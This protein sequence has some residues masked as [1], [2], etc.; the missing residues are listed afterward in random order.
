MADR[1]ISELTNLTGANLADDDEFPL[2]D[3]S[4]DETKAITFGEFKTALD[5]ATGFVRITG[6]TMTGALDVQSTITADGLDLGDNERIRLGASQDLQILHNGLHSYIADSGT[7]NLYIQTTAGLIVQNS[8]GTETL[9][10]FTENG[11]VDLYYDNSVKVATSST[12]IDVTGG[13]T[14]DAYSYLNGLRISG[15]DTGNTVYQQSGDLSISSASGDISLKPSGTNILHA[16][17]TGVG[18]GTSSPSTRLTVGAGV[19]S[20]EIRVDAG[21]GWADLTLNSNATNGG[22]IYFNDGSNAGEIF[23]YH[24]SDYMAF[25]TAGSEAMRIDSSGNVG[26]GVTPSYTLDIASSGTLLNMNSTNSNG[27]GTVYR[28]SGTAIGY[29]GSSKYIHSGTIGDFAIGTASTNNL[30]FGVNSSEKMRIDSSGNV[31]IG[32]SSPSYK[33]DVDV[34]APSSSDQVLGR[35]SSQAGLRSIGYVWDDSQS[36]LGIATLTNHAMTFHI[37][38]NSNEKMR[39]DTS[40]NLLVGTTSSFGSSGITLGSNVVYAAASSQNVANFQ[41]YTTDGEI[42]RFG[43]DGTTVGSIGTSSN[44]EITLAGLDAGVGLIDHALV[45]TQGDGLLYR[46]DNEVDLGRSDTRFKDLYLSGSI[47]IENGTGNVGVGKQALNSNTADSN[48]AVGYQAG[49]TNVSGRS[50]TF[51]G[52]DAGEISTSSFNTYIGKDAGKLI[53]SGQKNT[54]LGSYNGNQ[55]G[56]DIRTSSSNIVLSDGDG[57]PRLRID[58]NGSIY[59]AQNPGANPSASQSGTVYLGGVTNFPYFINYVGDANTRYHFEFGNT[60]GSVGNIATNGTAT[61]YNTSSDYRLKENVVAMTGATTRLK[62]LNPSQFNFI[63]DADTTVDGFL[64][65]EVQAIVPE[66]IHGVKDEVDADGNPVYQGIDQSKLV[67][68]LVATIKELEARITAL[69]NA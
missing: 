34:G 8:A 21:A 30:T 60:N 59:F 36:T 26:I 41:R 49:Y 38:G 64:A 57:N 43:K 61:S 46:N 31:G 66:A 12:G 10:T 42:V 37:N 67:P 32:T 47:E 11:S 5:T 24:V 68:L 28:N 55:G 20:E 53:T 2:V 54:I 18:I 29:V 9:A 23:Y 6:D 62:Q 1:K 16:T 22:H 63:A 39:L 69:E 58:T 48:T 56:L 15:A 17:N 19:S 4:A 50:N 3:T 25:N 33:L 44:T 52:N 27:I 7:G 35:F 40:G 13:V 51:I 14:T 45:P 65:H